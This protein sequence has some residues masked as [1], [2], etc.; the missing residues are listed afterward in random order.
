MDRLGHIFIFIVTVLG[1]FALL[2]SAP[3]V[4]G[5]VH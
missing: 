5:G 2:D 4:I 1:L 3:I